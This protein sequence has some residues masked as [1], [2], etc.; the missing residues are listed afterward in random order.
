MNRQGFVNYSKQWW[1]FSM[2]G[3]GGA[4]YGFP[5]KPRHD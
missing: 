1:Y 4:A 2:P 5:A 3:A